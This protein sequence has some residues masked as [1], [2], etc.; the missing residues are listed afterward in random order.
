MGGYGGNLGMPGG[1]QSTTPGMTSNPYAGAA[2]G[3]GGAAIIGSS[4][5]IYEVVGNIYG[6][7]S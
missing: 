2:P 3:A 1:P 6:G 5:I 4:F 7:I